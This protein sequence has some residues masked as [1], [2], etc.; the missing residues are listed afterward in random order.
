MLFFWGKIWDVQISWSKAEPT[1]PYDASCA[2]GTVQL[3]H[4]QLKY[5]GRIPIPSSCVGIDAMEAGI[6]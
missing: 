6:T 3:G 1:G 2:A 4:G 5:W